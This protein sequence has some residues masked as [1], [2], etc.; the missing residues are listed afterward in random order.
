MLTR[1]ILI[2]CGLGAAVWS[3]SRW[4]QA[5]QAAM[6][7]LLVEGA[8]RKWL[9]PGAQDIVYFAKDL[10]LLGAYAG[11]L[12]ASGHRSLPRLPALKAA[13]LVSALYGLAE[14]FNPRLPNPL[15]GVF[16]FK[17]YFWYIPLLFVL[18]D[19]FPDDGALARF[20]KRYVL[21]AIPIGLLAIAQFFAPASSPINTY[22]RAAE[23]IGYV[24]TF[25]SSSFVRVT[26]TFSYITGYS[27][28][29]F[30][31][32]IL[33][34]GI[35]ATVQWR[36][37]RNLQLYVA[38]GMTV[39]GILLTGSRGPLILLA[40]AF[41][42]YW[43]L[44]VARERGAGAT[45]SRL[46]LAVGLVL[47]LISYAASDA[48]DAYL[49]RAAG[50]A[51]DISSRLLSPFV[52]PFATFPAAGLEGYGI[53]ATHQ[54]A[55]A[56][57]KD[58]IPYSW[59]EGAG[60]EGEPGRIMLEL[61]LPGFLVFYFIRLY[62]ALFALRQARA[63]RTLFHRAIATAA[64]L[65]FFAQIPGSIVFDVTTDVYYWFFAGLLLTVMVLDR[66]ALPASQ[67]AVAP[68]AARRRPAAVPARVRLLDASR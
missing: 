40:A 53:G 45:F 17:A 2:S 21:T 30:A 44:A 61:G 51:A 59:L 6:F 29:L 34:L 41:P 1:L 37:R 49:G 26:A 56:L 28:Y 54:T 20:L 19:V 38:L 68:P 10:L 12:A 4:R 65:F 55:A 13:L 39:L 32:I 7:L 48:V 62:L 57:A 63:L 36:F 46:V 27:S 5:I 23:D 16:G 52:E 58:R 31:A 50:G 24:S 22:A 67:P 14:I 35:L 64:F 60:V 9:L 3:Y 25:G 15:V 43:W 8:I 33:L 66:V 47:L 42:F 18:P 11:W